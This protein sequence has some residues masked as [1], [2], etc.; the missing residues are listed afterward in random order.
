MSS[1]CKDLLSK[2]LVIK[3][4]ERLTIP[5][6]KQHSW[7]KAHFVTTDNKKPNWTE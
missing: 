6:I 2:L 7:M 5:G 3:P 4:S 1:T